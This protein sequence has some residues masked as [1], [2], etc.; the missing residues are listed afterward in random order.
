MIKKLTSSDQCSPWFHTPVVALSIMNLIE[1]TTIIRVEMKNP[2]F[3]TELVR[4][5]EWNQV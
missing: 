1:K 4:S 2:N 3:P 5:F